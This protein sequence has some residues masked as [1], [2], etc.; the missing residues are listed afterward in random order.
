MKDA[1]N[2][3]LEARRRPEGRSRRSDPRHLRDRTRAGR[4]QDGGA[5]PP[6]RR[7]HHADEQDRRGDARLDLRL[8]RS[9]EPVPRVHRSRRIRAA[10]RHLS[11]PAHGR[12]ERRFDRADD[13]AADRR[14]GACASASLRASSCH[15]WMALGIGVD[16]VSMLSSP[17]SGDPRRARRTLC[18]PERRGQERQDGFASV[19]RSRLCQLG[20][21]P[22]GESRSRAARPVR[23]RP[24]RCGQRP[25]GAAPF[26][27]AQTT[28]LPRVAA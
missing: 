16:P 2:L 17:E 21:T 12:G 15:Q 4:P 14:G 20:Q 9:V 11:Q 8:P 26:A 22:R 13:A 27:I 28:N 5:L 25:L 18:L 7:H 6:S 23:R 10:A 1:V 24:A 19:R 3:V